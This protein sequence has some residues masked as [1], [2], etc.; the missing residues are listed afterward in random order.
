MKSGSIVPFGLTVLLCFWALIC[1]GQTVTFV[2]LDEE[3]GAPLGNVQVFSHLKHQTPSYTGM[4]GKVVYTISPNDTLVF[5]R[6]KYAPIYL[7]LNPENIS[8]QVVITVKL[9]F[10]AHESQGYMT[11][12]FDKLQ[13]SEYHFVNDTISSN[14]K[15]TQ[16]HYQNPNSVRYTDK[17]FHVADVNI[18]GKAKPKLYYLKK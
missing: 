16:F 14:L 1:S 6:Q 8:N 10:I 11:R 2:A 15:I 18:D 17:A 7:H 9:K 3:T 5:F 4:D 13:K 12:S